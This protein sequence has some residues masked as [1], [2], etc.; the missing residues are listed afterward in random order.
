MENAGQS[1]VPV[2]E[3]EDLGPEL[4]REPLVGVERQDPEMPGLV[5]GEVLLVGV[6]R[7]RPL[8]DAV[9]VFAG[10]PDRPVRAVAVDDDDLVRDALEAPERGLDVVLLVDGRSGRRKSARSEINTRVASE[11]KARLPRSPEALA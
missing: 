1:G 6:V 5:V 8:E 3:G 9:G 2:L 10:D 11:G 7:P 4:G